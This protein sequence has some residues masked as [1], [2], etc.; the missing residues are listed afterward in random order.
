MALLL[1]VGPTQL[2]ACSCAPVVVLKGHKINTRALLLE[3]AVRAVS[4]FRATVVSIDVDPL[5]LVYRATLRVDE[6][7]KGVTSKEV[8]VWGRM[9]AGEC[10]WIP[11]LD[12][13]YLFFAD[14]FNF[15]EGTYTTNICTGTK[16]LPD[17]WEDLAT[18]ASW[19]GCS[20]K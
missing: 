15:K 12:E 6:T 3:K 9:S 8:F 16:P 20:N 17:A 13:S 19:D 1:V 11:V 2:G 18:L 4:I 7:L 5:T 14:S 10:L